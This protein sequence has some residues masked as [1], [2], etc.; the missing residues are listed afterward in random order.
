VA[1]EIDQFFHVVTP[2]EHV[3]SDGPV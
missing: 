1:K 2:R 3:E